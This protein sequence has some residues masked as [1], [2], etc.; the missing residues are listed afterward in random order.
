MEQPASIGVNAT[1]FT[2]RAKV[3]IKQHFVAGPGLT[4]ITGDHMP[5]LGRFIDTVSD[6]DKDRIDVHHEYDE[7]VMIEED[8]WLGANVTILKGVT[9]GRGS[10]VAAGAVVTKDVPR[11]SIVGGVPAKIIKQR[12][13]KED[14]LIHESK[15]Y[16]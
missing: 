7:D 3:I 15:L 6:A 13:S 1:I 5:V 11:Y 4:I 14:I 9:I 12:M 8:V 2:T 10:I 16:Q